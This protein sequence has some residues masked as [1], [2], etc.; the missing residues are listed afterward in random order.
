MVDW[1]PFRALGLYQV[2]FRSRAVGSVLID[3]RQ[4]SVTDGGLDDPIRGELGVA[5]PDG[6]WHVAFLH[7][8]TGISTDGPSIKG[9]DARLQLPEFRHDLAITIRRR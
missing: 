1:P 4:R 8:V 9:G 2:T 5:I 6:N 3:E 7:P